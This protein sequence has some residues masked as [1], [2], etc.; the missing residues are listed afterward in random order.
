MHPSAWSPSILTGLACALAL[1]GCSGEARE[2]SVYMLRLRTVTLPLINVVFKVSPGLTE[3]PI[4]RSAQHAA[5][6][7][8]QCSDRIDDLTSVPLSLR[9]RIA[10]GLIEVL[11]D[12]GHAAGSLADCIN[13]RLD[14]SRLLSATTTA[15]SLTVQ[16]MRDE[17]P[18]SVARSRMDR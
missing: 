7:L 18:A 1:L 2:D 8:A 14:G 17:R 9:F 6:A 4:E 10:S 13:T 5:R 12:P 11:R 15:R 16:L 3:P